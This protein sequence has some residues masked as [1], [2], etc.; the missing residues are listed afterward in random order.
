MIYEFSTK[1]MSDLLYDD[2]SIIQDNAGINK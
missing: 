1:D 2:L